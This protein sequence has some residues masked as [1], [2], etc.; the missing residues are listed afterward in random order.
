V[1]PAVATKSNA[2][3]ETTEAPTTTTTVP[4]TTTTT[5]V[6]TTT[7]TTT[8]TVPPTTTTTTTTT[9]PPTTTTTT[10]TTTV[11]VA[12]P[13]I[14]LS[15]ESLVAT[16]GEA[17]A[18]YAI[19]STGGPVA[20]YSIAPQLPA[21]LAFSSST[22][23]IS[24]TPTAAITTTTFTVTATN[25]S[26]S[27]SRTFTLR[28]N[29]PFT[30]YAIS[31][32]GSAQDRANA[33]TPLS[34]G[35]MI[36][37]GFITQDATFGSTTLRTTTPD[38]NSYIAKVSPTGD[39][40]WA[41]IVSHGTLAAYG[42]NGGELASVQVAAFDDDSIVVTGRFN[43]TVTFGS[44]TLT[45]SCTAEHGGFF[46]AKMNATRNWLW[47]KQTTGCGFAPTIR[48]VTVTSDNSVIMSG[49]WVY[50][51]LAFG[52]NTVTPVGGIGVV[53]QISSNGN[54][55]WVK[56]LKADCEEIRLDANNSGDIF[57]YGS[58]INV[59]T[60]I[61]TD[62]QY[63]YALKIVITKLNS[64]GT[65]QW[66]TIVPTPEWVRGHLKD[67][68]VQDDGSLIVAGTYTPGMELGGNVTTEPGIFV[69]K[70]S[71]N[72]QWQWIT[73]GGGH[74]YNDGVAGL[75]IRADGTIM[76]A[77]HYGYWATPVYGSHSLAPVPDAARE[78]AILEMNQ[79]GVW[80]SARRI[81]T[82]G[83]G[84]ASIDDPGDIE[85]LPNGTPVL[86]GMTSS[87]SLPIGSRTITT[88]GSIDIFVATL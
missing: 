78:I 68:R 71:S 18:G 14:S 69:G 66:A 38:G 34:D 3:P 77:A 85:I 8:T 16:V 10:T 74:N 87:A 62:W 32:G 35:S 51:P 47:A 33:M 15:S 20:T 53:A 82:S 79:S 52:T 45:N 26:G 46:A 65:P 24:G 56:T 44:T 30:G 9:V 12:L 28:V 63:S 40:L 17:L 6:P 25:R 57:F 27:V 61:W 21:G 76:V 59:G 80:L 48:G 72:G 83:Q 49:K 64:S 1:S 84:W 13:T 42:A 4:P 55:G 22:G 2:L 86:L 50:T 23:Q 75:A 7:S 60:N 70:L 29:V 37:S 11:P 36:I 58:C 54:W 73:T 41:E 39:W 67:L 5:T 88:V 19:Q 43:G 31:A 81:G